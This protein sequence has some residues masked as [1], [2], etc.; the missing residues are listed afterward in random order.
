M[1]RNYTAA[2]QGTSALSLERRPQFRVYDFQSKEQRRTA[3]RKPAQPYSNKRAFLIGS[4]IACVLMFGFFISDL[5]EQRIIDQ[6]GDMPTQTVV[7][8]SGDSLWKISQRYAPAG[9]QTSDMV[10]WIVATNSLENSALTPGQEL[11]VPL[12]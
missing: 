1:S 10:E 5:K 9:I 11:I 8:K 6:M 3:Q 4:L 12:D 7:V 2:V